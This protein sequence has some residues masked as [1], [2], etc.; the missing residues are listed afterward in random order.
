M[1]ELEYVE[2]PK[3]VEM[4]NAPGPQGPT[5]EQGD[6]GIQGPIGLTGPQ[7]DQ[8]IQ[9][10]KGDKG[11]Q[12]IQGVQGQQGIQGQVGPAGLDWKGTW[13]A[14]TVYDE[15]DAV[16]YNGA[17]WFASTGAPAGVAPADTGDNP[18]Q[19]LAIRGA[20]GIQGQQGIQGVQ[21][22][23]GFKGDQGDLTVSTAVTATGTQT[24]STLPATYRWTLAGNT[25]VALG[26][27]ANNVA[28]T[29][30]LTIAQ[31]STGGP[32]T[33]TWPGT[34]KW[35]QSAPAPLMPTSPNAQLVIHLFWDGAVWRGVVGGVY[36]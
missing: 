8:G 9:G 28:G 21:G 10:E 31:P 12:G 2:N 35:S 32:F 22:I 11:D 13:L 30:T 24:L 25:T 18:W 15:N 27:Q 29:I 3:T 5:G 36:S 17:S 33:V 34:I 7:G 26:T 19:P 23:Q 1:T 4:L 6:Q 16:Y 20:Q 14:Q